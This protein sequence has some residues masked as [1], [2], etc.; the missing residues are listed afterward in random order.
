M[1]DFQLLVYASHF[2]SFAKD[3]GCLYQVSLNFLHYD[4]AKIWNYFCWK[5]FYALPIIN[6]WFVANDRTSD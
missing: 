1:L 3:Q 4:S 6:S 2:V 5:I